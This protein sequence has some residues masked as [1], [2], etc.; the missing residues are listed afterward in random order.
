MQFDNLPSGFVGL[1]DLGYHTDTERE[2]GGGGERERFS[3][4]CR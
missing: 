4:V 1:E 3:S 2:R